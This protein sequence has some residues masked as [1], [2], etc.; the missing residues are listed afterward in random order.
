MKIN[1]DDKLNIL[2]TPAAT[3]ANEPGGGGG[4]IKDENFNQHFIKIKK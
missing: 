2:E 3:A 4:S 1:I